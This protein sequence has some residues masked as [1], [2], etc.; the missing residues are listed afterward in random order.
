MMAVVI[1]LALMTVSPFFF[2]GLINKVKAVWAGRKGAPLLQPYYDFFRL[3]KKGE[4]ISG[5]TSI[6]FKIAP[7]V[8]ISAVLFALL[9]VPIPL[10]GSVINFQGDF[11]LFAYA[12]GLAKFFTVAAALDTGS[13]FEGMGASREVTYSTIVEPAFFVVIG[14]LALLTHQISFDSIFAAVN[15]STHYTALIKIL[16]VAS[17][18]IM[19]LAE[20]SRVPVDDPNTHLELTMIHE[21][22]I[23]D[24]SGPDL[25]FIQ[26]A[27]ALKMTIISILIADLLVPSYLGLLPTLAVLAFIMALV[28]LSVGIVESLI[29]RSRISHIPQF[30]FLMTTLS[31]TAFAVIAFFLFGVIG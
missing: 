1:V 10:I 17:L 29:A 21:V 28:F 6:V 3:L 30:L 5:T 16:L 15:F 9:I 20:G 13:S 25:A 7:S 12:L 22:M 11:V 8:N 4:V 31:L 19:L 27:A 2:I 26:Y 18:F 23:L 24:Y 14:S